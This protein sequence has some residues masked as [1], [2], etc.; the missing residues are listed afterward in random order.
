M[1]NTTTCT[2]GSHRWHL[3]QAG[4]GP[5]L[6]LLHGAGSDARSWD[7]IAPHLVQR[8]SLLAP[9]LPGHG[10]APLTTD[11][12]LTLPALVEALAALLRQLD[13]RP[14]AIVGHSAGAALALGLSLQRHTASAPTIGIAPALQEPPAIA[15]G[16]ARWMGQQL[17]GSTTLLSLIAGAARSPLLARLI[18]LQAHARL[19]PIDQQRYAALLRQP[20]H[21]HAALTLMSQWRLDSVT[22]ALSQLTVPVHFIAGARDPWYPPR[23]VERFTAAIPTA[24]MMSIDGAGHLPHEERPA[25]CAAAIFA[26]LDRV[27]S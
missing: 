10:D 6:L 19:N 9:S 12:D 17:A 15:I 7:P 27:R 8:C 22:Q 20:S 13:L 18:L 16:P 14:A 1:M 21:L 4:T 5:L 2:V 25:E 26:F 11:A 23:I 24:S 3:R